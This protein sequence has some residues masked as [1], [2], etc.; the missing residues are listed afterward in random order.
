VF[1]GISTLQPCPVCGGKCS[2]DS[3]ACLVNADCGSGPTCEQDT[4][5]DD[6]RQGL[7]I[8]GD[9]AGD[10]CD[11]DATNSNFPATVGLP[12]G[13]GYSYD[14]L[15]SAGLNVTAPDGIRHSSIVT[16]GTSSLTATLPC[17][18]F[19]AE[20]ESCL[21][22]VCEGSGVA[23]NTDDDCIAAANVC[24]GAPSVSCS[25]NADCQNAVVGT[26][27]SI[28]GQNRCSLLT[29][30][31]CTSNSDCRG[32]T[33]LGSCIA[34]SCSSD[35]GASGSYPNECELFDCTDLGG[36]KG[37]CTTGPDDTYCDGLV[38]SDGTPMVPCNTNANCEPDFPPANYGDCTVTKRRGCFT[39]SI[40]ATGT[41]HPTAP[42]L[43]TTKCVQPADNLGVN[44]VVGL[45]GPERSI[46]QKELASF[47]SGG[48]Y[49]PGA[50]CP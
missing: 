39:G 37:E 41:V 20:S 25:V 26:C 29:S 7:C 5:G 2:D 44:L 4:A 50:G 1:L 16:T 40:S 23:C 6:N 24:T 27:T 14:C 15:P 18:G 34:P 9:N 42:V 46:A 10:P 13:G 22:R 19:G 47:C 21:C 32:G 38:R 3:S 49:T 8:G 33:D 43:A 30:L 36:G 48:P 28:A 45:P 17:S 12:G 11:I 31:A 35:G